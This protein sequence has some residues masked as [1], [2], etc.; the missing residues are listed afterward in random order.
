M[1]GSTNVLPPPLRPE[2]L[3][4]RDER[5]KVAD[6]STSDIGGLASLHLEQSAQHER[7]RIGKPERKLGFTAFCHQGFYQCNC[8]FCVRGVNPAKMIDLG[9]EPPVGF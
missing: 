9:Q 7:P 8:D 6:S 2:V 1:T 4:R 5:S 3:V